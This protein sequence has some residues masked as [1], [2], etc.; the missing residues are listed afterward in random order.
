M[1]G[2]LGRLHDKPNDDDP[3]AKPDIYRS[4]SVRTLIQVYKDDINKVRMESLK[5]P[6]KL[7]A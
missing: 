7:D 1:A 3:G 4:G 5:P 6:S 2:I